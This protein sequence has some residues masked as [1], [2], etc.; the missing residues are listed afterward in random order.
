MK[1]Y[2]SKARPK[3]GDQVILQLL[4]EEVYWEVD[5]QGNTWIIKVDNKV[6]HYASRQIKRITKL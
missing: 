5:K 1:Y 2:K 4:E 6:Y 3:V